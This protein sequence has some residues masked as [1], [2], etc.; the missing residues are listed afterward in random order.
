MVAPLLGRHDVIKFMSQSRRDELAKLL[1]QITGSHVR[2]RVDTANIPESPASDMTAGQAVLSDRDRALALPLVRTIFELFPDATLTNIRN[3]NQKEKSSTATAAPAHD[4][5]PTLPLIDS[6][7]SAN[8]FNE[9]HDASPDE[10][11]DDDDA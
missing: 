11:M 10:E 9:D 4:A 7:A 3:E 5:Q 2:L 8:P 6:D 1:S